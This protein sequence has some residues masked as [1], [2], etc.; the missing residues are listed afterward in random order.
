MKKS[1]NKKFRLPVVL[2]VTAIM[3]FSVIMVWGNSSDWGKIKMQRINFVY[4]MEGKEY[5]GSA[6]LFSPKTATSENKAP[7]ITIL[8]GASSYSYALKAYGIELA[9]RGFVTIL[10]D[11]PGQGQ[12][13]FVGHARGYGNYKPDAGTG[14]S[15]EDASGYIIAVTKELQN[16]DFVDQDKLTIAGFSAGQSWSVQCVSNFYPGVYQNVGTLSGYTAQNRDATLAAGVNFFGINGNANV[17]KD[18]DG[19]EMIPGEI[20]G[21]GS[22]EDG[23]ADYCWR[24]PAA[25]QH[26]MQPTTPGII[27]A[28]CNMMQLIYPTGTEIPQ[29][30]SIFMGAEIFS[31]IAIICLFILLA[32][33]IKALLGMKFFRSLEREQPKSFPVFF[34]KADSAGK[35]RL[36]NILFLSFRIFATIALYEILGARWQI[37]PLFAGTAWAGLWFNIWVPFLIANGLVNVVIYLVWHK[38]CGKPNGGNAYAY[39]ISWTGCNALNIVKSLILGLAMVFTV[40][41][42]LNYLDILLTANF[43]VMIFGMISFNMEHMLQMPFYIILYFFILFAASLTQYITNPSYS[44]GTARG[45]TIATIRNTIIAIMPYLL[46]VIWNTLKGMNVIKMAAEHPI[47]QFAPLDNM[48]GYPIMMCLVTPIMD[49]LYRKTK[50]IWPGI[51]VCAMLLGVLIA[52]NYSLNETWFG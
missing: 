52:S 8:G 20:C 14:T 38:V 23:T 32:Y 6:L 42:L 48:Y 45:N 12:S 2:I 24:A 37:I 22:W 40:T 39:G 35:R 30:S 33:L 41:S 10:C 9:R 46:M 51:I 7:G 1:E 31:G 13:S 47:D 34:E 21:V 4:S 36:Y 29:D 3:L 26:Q 25:V 11:M 17:P 43:K 19:Y 50:N 5:T 16:M 44:D 15:G 28:A 49:M 27:L 18:W